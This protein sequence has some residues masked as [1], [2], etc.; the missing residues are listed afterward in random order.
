MSILARYQSLDTKLYGT[1]LPFMTSVQQPAPLKRRAEKRL[2]LNSLPLN[3]QKT[4]K[5]RSDAELKYCVWFCRNPLEVAEKSTFSAADHLCRY[6]PPPRF[7]TPCL[8]HLESQIYSK[9]KTKKVK[10]ELVKLLQRLCLTL[11]RR[12]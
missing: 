7:P 2:P 9:R 12:W 1:G 3:A 5:H 10:S 6:F 8:Q 4:I 11:Q